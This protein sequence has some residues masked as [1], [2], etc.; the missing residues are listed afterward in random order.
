MD[1][2]TAKPTPLEQ[3]RVPHHLIDVVDPD[4]VL[5]LA[6]REGAYARAFFDG[7]N[8]QKEADYAHDKP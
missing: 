2:G 1:I 5:T 8:Y 7:M 6:D 4:Q 3:L